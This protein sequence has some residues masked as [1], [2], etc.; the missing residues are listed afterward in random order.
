MLSSEADFREKFKSRFRELRDEMTQAEF[1]KHLGI[2][3]PTVG[4]YENGE[5]IPD[6]LTIR[7]I[8]NICDVP[9]DYLLGITD[10]RTQENI[11]IVDELGLTEKSIYVLKALKN[12]ATK[13]RAFEIQLQAINLLLSEELANFFQPIL[14]YAG[15]KQRLM[16]RM[17]NGED[18]IPKESLGDYLAE[19]IKDYDSLLGYYDWLIGET[20][21]KFAI[22]LAEKLYMVLPEDEDD[23]ERSED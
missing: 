3:R 4:F 11:K 18:T 2:S 9:A 15:L 20:Q 12:E 16:Y 17:R 1:A 14:V 21:R 6:A 13:K 8:A 23:A 19:I 5:R 10:S 7:K 22:E